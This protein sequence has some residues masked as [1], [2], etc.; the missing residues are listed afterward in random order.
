M[1]TTTILLT[2]LFIGSVF[3]QENK[4][5][6][7]SND[8]V[9][10]YQD[11]LN[12]AAAKKTRLDIFIQVPFKEI[13]FVK[14]G[15][16]YDGGYSVIVSVYDED[17]TTLV[18]EKLWNEKINI[19]SSNYLSSR[20]N[21]N[22]SYRSFELPP[23]KYFIRTVVT[24]KD[25][26]QEFSAENVFVVKDFSEKPSMS[27]IMLV[28]N[29]TSVSGD[30]KIIPNVSRNIINSGKGIDIFYEIYSDTAETEELEYVITNDKDKEVVFSDTKEQKLKAGTTQVFYTFIDTTLS[31]GSYHLS[32]FLK[33]ADGDSVLET[34]KKFF[35]RIMG[36]PGNI[37]D[38]DK[39]IN[40]MVY[41]ASP[42]EMSKME[43]GK[44]EK[45]K[46]ERFL[47]F[48]K[49]KDPSPGNE[50]NEMFEE[51]FRRVDYSNKNFS[52]YI[53]GWRSDR[54]MVYIILGAPNNIDRHPFE[55][56]SKPYEVWQYYELNRNFVFV[57]ETGFGDYRL[58]TPLYG[59]LFRYRN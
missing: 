40:E 53:E 29:R 26:R 37:V 2:L 6:G 50:R 51:Y 13:Q 7:I 32:V 58:V 48:W 57:D 44:D 47:E 43:D 4:S 31:L 22:L 55:Y 23:A 14:S 56:D 42:D 18:Q 59:D 45:E 34:T 28:A 21:F 27:D 52:Q 9:K 5:D 19:N 17:K 15:Q 49:S 20:E 33:K 46:T 24:D 3:C 10:F 12:F 25:S 16:G 8:R 36:L 39:A 11:F 41:I 38:I 54:G 1:K 35:S 30:N